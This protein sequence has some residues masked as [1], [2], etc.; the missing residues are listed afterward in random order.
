MK[1]RVDE[2]R[3]I[4]CELCQDTCPEVFEVKEDGFS[5]IIVAEIR[6]EWHDCCRESA[7][8]CPTEAII[9]EED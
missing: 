7:E 6:P 9:I 3:C 5:H 8:I 4:G 1:V 2:D